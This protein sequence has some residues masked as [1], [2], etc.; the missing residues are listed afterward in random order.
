[1]VSDLIESS[2]VGYEV[3]GLLFGGSPAPD[4]L[5]PRARD[6]FPSATMMQAYGMT[7]TNSVAVSIAGGDYTARPT[8]TGLASPVNEIMIVREGK[9]VG[10]GVSGEV[11]LRG[12]NIM[13][14]YWRDQEATSK[15]ITNDGWLRTGD[16]GFLDN[17]GFLYIKDRIKDIIIRGGENIDS[18][19]VENAL[20]R[21]PRVLEAAAVG[22]PDERLGELVAAS[23]QPSEAESQAPS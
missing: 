9:P 10:P 12:P 16:L 14:C 3:D 18:V 17:E 8:S 4:T 19:S 6:A 21:D 5:V 13:Q 1:M 15:S 7:E 2:L 20:Y 11:L 23:S 22:V